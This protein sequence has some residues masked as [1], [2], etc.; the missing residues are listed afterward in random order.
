V[1]SKAVLIATAFL[2]LPIAPVVVAADY[3]YPACIDENRELL[4]ENGALAF[5]WNNEYGL[6]GQPV[7]AGLLLLTEQAVR[8][9]RI[10]KAQVFV[11]RKTQRVDGYPI[12][13]DAYYKTVTI[14][15]QSEEGQGEPVEN[16]KDLNFLVEISPE[17]LEAMK[18][19][20][21]GTADDIASL[22]EMYA[23]ALTTSGIGMEKAMGGGMSNESIVQLTTDIAE[24]CPIKKAEIEDTSYSDTF[25]NQSTNWGA[26]SPLTFLAG[27]AC[28]ARDAALYMRNYTDESPSESVAR[29][30]ENLTRAMETPMEVSSEPIGGVPA[31]K[32][33]ASDLNI[34]YA[35]ED[36]TRVEIDTMSAW[37][38]TE[39]FARRKIRFE[40]TMESDGETRPFFLEKEFAD[41]RFV[42]NT[43]LYEPYKEILRMGGMLG[44]EELA[45]VAEAQR[46]LDE[47]ESQLAAMSA[48]ERQMMEKMMGSQVEQ[49]KSLASA[50]T[51]EIEVITSEIIVNP[52]FSTDATAAM[53]VDGSAGL[54]TIIQRHLSTLGYY[55]GAISG[56]LT[57][58]TVIA[59]SQFE[60]TRG[61]PVTGEAT[62]AL[63][64]KLAAE[65]QTQT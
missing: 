48:A 52:D 31:Q 58:E 22:M 1:Q 27:P 20:A 62:Q 36:G 9:E 30:L 49:M 8:S 43:V 24:G 32:I 44:P 4:V 60:A 13:T 21:G 61:M 39:Q 6:V 33:S 53:P 59:I 38:D 19:E 64:Q 47:F 37:I 56:E 5:G 41:F 28:F 2:I 16:C 57:T 46:K 50:G 23:N 29:E 42:P 34:E 55:S 63:A 7:T 11:L 17:E 14:E 10:G 40:G 18:R 3:S 12:H 54:V 35:N 26:F 51:V 65:V 15:T 25:I 45:E